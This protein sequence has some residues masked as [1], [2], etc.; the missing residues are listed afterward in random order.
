MDIVIFS[1]TLRQLD[2][3]K[4]TTSSQIF[5]LEFARSLA[6]NA[7]VSIISLK[8]KQIERDRDISLYPIDETRKVKYSIKE[9]IQKNS[10][11]LENNKVMM[12]Y[13]YDYFILNQL[14]W[15]C[16]ELETRLISYTF[17]THKAAIEHRKGLRRFVIDCYFK[18]GIKK[19]NRID[20]IILFNEEAYKEFRLRI[21]YLIS[22]VGINEN[23]ISPQVYKRNEDKCF[24][25]V[26][27]GSLESYN[28]VQEMIDAMS[29][30]SSMNVSLNIFGNG[31][32]KNEVI[33]KSASDP[34]IHYRGLVPRG[35][36]DDVIQ[37]ADLLLNL[38]NTEHYV[39][40]FAFPSK[41]IQYLSSGIPVLSTRVLKD[42]TFNNVAFVLDDLTAKKTSDLIAYII[43]NPDEQQKRA[44]LAKSYIRTN[45][46]WTDIIKDVDNFFR[47]ISP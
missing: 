18:L 27:A 37:R 2:I 42:K 35:E 19:L 29:Y 1:K 14:K 44:L 45:Y 7:N 17:D 26:Y 47:K 34:R 23:V 33:K 41:L 24:N 15:V 16:K 46:L 8:A 13:G 10:L 40:K 22:K 25:I 4:A 30:L 36:L 20:G 11:L 43:D 12:F 3:N 5:E 39:N 28:G 38:R 6:S 31:T 32:L 9:L 21:P